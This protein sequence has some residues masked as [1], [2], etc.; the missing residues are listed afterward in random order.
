MTSPL[1][2]AAQ[3]YCSQACYHA[4][5]KGKTRI[6]PESKPCEEC[7][8]LVSRRVRE[9]RTEFKRRRFCGPACAY[10]YAKGRHYY[11]ARNHDED[12]AYA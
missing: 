6:E 12:H 1:V 7:G 10:A 9:S 2:Y 11:G 4:S 5:R 8:Q 3:T